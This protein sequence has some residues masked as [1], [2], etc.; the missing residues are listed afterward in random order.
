MEE[1]GMNEAK[2]AINDQFSLRSGQGAQEK[3]RDWAAFGDSDQET[4][5]AKLTDESSL[6]GVH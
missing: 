1:F 5:S 2:T 4:L 3:E 6:G